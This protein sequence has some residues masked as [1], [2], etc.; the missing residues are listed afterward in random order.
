MSVSDVTQTCH[1]DGH[2]YM[3]KEMVKNP[4]G[5]LLRGYLE[6]QRVDGNKI[7]I[8]RI[9]AVGNYVVQGV[10]KWRAVVDTGMN[11]RVL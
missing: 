6:D 5:F 2:I 8:Y 3:D 9:V 1:M 4:S 10:N 11:I 7:K